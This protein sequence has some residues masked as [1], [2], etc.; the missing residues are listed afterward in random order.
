MVSLLKFR[1]YKIKWHKIN[2]H[3]FTTIGNIFNFSKV[4]VG[5]KTYGILHV[6]DYS[7]NPTRL[8]IGSYCSIACGVKFLLGGEHYLN[9]IT[10]YPI[11]AK[12]YNLGNEALSKG[13]IILNDDVWVGENSLICSGVTIGQGAVIAAGSVVTKNVEP[14]AIVGG[15]P[16]KIIKY[17]FDKV[18]IEKLLSINIEKVLSKIN[19]KN[20]YLA[21]KPFSLS[22]IDNLN[23]NIEED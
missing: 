23:I 3:N 16:A 5:N 9:T 1:F 6:V 8:I 21:Y 4:S 18:C 7:D 20:L 10:T 2:S 12:L 13:D 19:D 22:L 15:N 11:K 17:R 14:Y